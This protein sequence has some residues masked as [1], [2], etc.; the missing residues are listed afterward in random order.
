MKERRTSTT[1]SRKKSS[2]KRSEAKKRLDGQRRS[3]ENIA[4]VMKQVAE[5]GT[6]GCCDTYQKVGHRAEKIS[7]SAERV[8]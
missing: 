5:L 4:K 3:G 6:T 1:E 8:G 2:D 7:R